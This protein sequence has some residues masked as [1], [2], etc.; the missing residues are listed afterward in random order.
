MILGHESIA[1]NKKSGQ[2]NK[3]ERQKLSKA[4]TE[5]KLNVTAPL[6]GGEIVTAG[7]VCLNEVKSKT[8]ESKI[9]KNLYF[10]GEVLDIDGLCGGFNL[11]NCWSTGFVA[12]SALKYQL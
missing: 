8:M 6:K 3:T 10:C 12:G 1:H 9:V 4:L 5:L 11:Q 2:L 7:G